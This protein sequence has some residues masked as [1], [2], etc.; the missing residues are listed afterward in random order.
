VIDQAI[1]TIDTLIPTMLIQPFIENA[2]WHGIMPQEGKGEVVLNFIV[3]DEKHLLIEVFDNG[4]GYKPEKLNSKG[5]KSIGL[6]MTEQRLQLMS[7]IYKKD[8]SMEVLNIPNKDES[9][10]GTLVKILIPIDLH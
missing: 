8:F 10:S 6:K 9:L 3:K 1:D 4:V 7:E 2:I 5:H